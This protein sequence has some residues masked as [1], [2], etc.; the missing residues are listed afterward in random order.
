MYY[1]FSQMHTSNILLALVLVYTDR[2]QLGIAC[3]LIVVIRCMY[4][5]VIY[6]NKDNDALYHQFSVTMTNMLD[7]Q[8]FYAFRQFKLR[9]DQST[10]LTGL[11]RCLTEVAPLI[12]GMDFSS[13]QTVKS[14]GKSLFTSG[15]SA[16]SYQIWDSRPLHPHLLRYAANDVKYLLPMKEVWARDC[17][18]MI[19]IVK[20]AYD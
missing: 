5:L 13:W 9:Q 3:V 18:A 7:L 12:P 6:T 14:A 10:H 15:Q 11:E 8:V 2:K 4:V 16:A 17:S 1:T 19:P 20:Q